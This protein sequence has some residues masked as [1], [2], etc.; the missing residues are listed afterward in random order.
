MQALDLITFVLVIIGAVNWG[1][2][3]WLNF[4]LVRT[5]F[6]PADKSRY[7]YSLI[8]RVVYA[9]VGACAVVQLILRFSGAAA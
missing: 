7:E 8:S 6:P 5:I 1:L 4:D 3:G 9:L 2:V